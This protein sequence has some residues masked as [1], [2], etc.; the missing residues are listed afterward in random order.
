MLISLPLVAIAGPMLGEMVATMPPLFFNPDAHL[1]VSASIPF[2]P[3]EFKTDDNLTLRGW[4]FP[5][6]KPDG[7]AIVYAPATS[8]DQRSGLSLVEPLHQAGFHVLLFSYRGSGGSEGSRFGFTYGARESVD[9]DAA[10]N[11]LYQSRGIQKIGAIGHSA[12]AVSIILSAARNPRIAA[13]A[14]ASPFPSLEA[15]WETSR[16]AFF[17]KPLYRFILR[18]TELRKG[19][20]H[21]QVR[22]EDQIAQIAPR[23]VLLI[24]GGADE[25][26]TNSQAVDL[27]RRASGPKQFLL[28]DSASHHEVRSPGLDENASAIIEFFASAFLQD[29]MSAGL[30]SSIQR[31]Q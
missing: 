9:I 13:I 22:A 27:F 14:A 29:A 6:E 1:P 3:V 18:M 12:G 5:A 16:P 2:E 28:L 24:Q 31:H 8:H 17:P 25:R 19:F 7:P 23:P 20:S 26:V 15:V 30:Q 11:Y 21:T 4:F 10:V